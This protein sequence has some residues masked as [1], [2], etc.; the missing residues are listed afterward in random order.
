MTV[1]RLVAPSGYPHD[2]AAMARG[3]RRLRDAGCTVQNEDV[4]ARTH[5]RFAGTDAERADDLNA[6]AEVDHLPDIVLAVRGGYGATRLLE[7]L[8][9]DDLRERLT[10][11]ATVLV[12]HSDFTAIQLALYAR[13]GLVTFGGP[14]LGPDF[15]A[16]HVSTLTLPHFWQTIRADRSEARWTCAKAITPREGLLWGGNLAVLC[17]LL[18]TPYM[19]SIE[20]GILYV[21][22]VGE[23]PFR[24]ERLLYQLHLS[25]VL[26]RQQAV[27]IGDFSRCRPAEYDNGYTL[28]EAFSQLERIAGVPIVHGLKFGHEPDKFTLPLG[29]QARLEADGGE[30]V[31]AYGGYPHLGA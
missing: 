2:H 19:P 18:G 6:L 30:A 25:G 29:A 14:M 20:G 16:E 15:G 26:A 27:L 9:Y 31:L 7:H 4:L 5:L 1:V 8:H 13:S 3:L 28:A 17:S 22:D 10:A 11:S 24:I 23:P 12:G 21:E